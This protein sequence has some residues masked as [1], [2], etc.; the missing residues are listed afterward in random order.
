MQSI[1]LGPIGTTAGNF[2]RLVSRFGYRFGHNSSPR[3][4]INHFVK[5]NTHSL[6]QSHLTNGSCKRPTSKLSLLKWEE[7]VTTRPTA[8]IHGTAMCS[9]K[10]AT[11]TGQHR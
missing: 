10:T 6:T 3:T 7:A 4:N 9:M 2:I 5:I 8:T 1:L 11:R